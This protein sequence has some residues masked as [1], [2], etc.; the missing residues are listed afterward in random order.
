ISGQRV[1]PGEIENLLLASGMA[2]AAAVFAAPIGETQV[3]IACYVAKSTTGQAAGEADLRQYLRDNLPSAWVPSLVLRCEALPLNA[4]G[5]LD[6]AALTERAIEALQQADQVSD[7]VQ[8]V[9]APAVQEGWHQVLGRPP[10]G[11]DQDFFAAG[12]SSLLL[13]KFLAHIREKTGCHLPVA[14]AFGA[15][16]PLGLSA[17][18]A[19]IRPVDLHDG[20]ICTKSAGE[21]PPLVFLPGFVATGPN[22]S[23]LLQQLPQEQGSYLLQRPVAPASVARRSFADHARYYAKLLQHS[24]FT[25]GL[26]LTGFSYGGAEAFET[27][28]HLAALEMPPLSLTV[29]DN[30]PVFR[31][32]TGF[33]P[34]WATESRQAEVRRRAHELVP[35]QGDMA[36]IRGERPGLISFAMLAY[37]WEDFV[38]GEVAVHLVPADHRS[39]LHAQAKMTA[40]ALQPGAPPH[41]LVSPLPGASDRRRVSRFLATGEHEKAFD[42]ICAVSRAYPHH[43]WS[44]LI[45]DRLAQSMQRDIYDLLQD[46]MKSA[47]QRPPEAVPAL[48]WYAARAEVLRQLQAPEAALAELDIARQA[49]RD[50]GAARDLSCGG[51][52]RDLE[53]HYGDLLQQLG[54]VEEA[55][56]V[57]E[58]AGQRCGY[59]PEIWRLL[60]I[61]LAK[62]EKFQSALPILKAVGQTYPQDAELQTWLRR[63]QKAIG[64]AA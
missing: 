37:G 33:D 18:L 44:V 59:K 13:I 36:L 22:L 31:R 30:G 26:H 45:A 52:I 10:Q 19:G 62:V 53:L 64:T 32:L 35:L 12:G 28:R 11:G 46:W 15:P 43:P 20:L 14:E 57:L 4:S 39:I 7:T 1:E 49:T 23:D 60:G 9:L 24:A 51:M 50:S 16:T 47:P 38:S 42:L 21:M 63:T 54:R 17:L 55:I 5:K 48:A 34:G 2:S 27:A 29:I 8:G 40:A 25:E 58:R 56:E 3:L 41:A 61:C 6:R